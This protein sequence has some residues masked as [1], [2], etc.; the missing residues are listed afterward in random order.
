[1]GSG[2]LSPVGVRGPVPLR[3]YQRP[4]PLWQ[5]FGASQRPVTAELRRS[6]R[7]FVMLCVRYLP[8]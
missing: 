8:I 1:M 7:G 5:L 4:L 6:G 2:P 3:A